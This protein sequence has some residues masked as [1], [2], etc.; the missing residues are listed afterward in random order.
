ML[1]SLFPVDPWAKALEF[2]L[3]RGYAD[4]TKAGSI[5]NLKSF[6]LESLVGSSGKIGLGYVNLL[7]GKPTNDDIYAHW[8]RL[9]KLGNIFEIRVISNDTG[10]SGRWEIGSRWQ[11]AFEQMEADVLA[12]NQRHT[13]SRRAGGPPPKRPTDWLEFQLTPEQN[14]LYVAPTTEFQF[15]L[16]AFYN[17]LGGSDLRK[18]S[19]EDATALATFVR[20]G[21]RQA[22]SRR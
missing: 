21:L 16:Y 2:L 22:A 12:Q 3:S 9:A 14:P 10:L 17:K 8:M 11:A 18:L 1:A 13:A 15:F 7:G 20:D 19:T 4:E 5:A 6:D